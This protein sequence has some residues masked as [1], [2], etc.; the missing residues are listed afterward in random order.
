MKSVAHSAIAGSSAGDRGW[1]EHG[2]GPDSMHEL[3]SQPR[4]WQHVPVLSAANEDV[5]REV[6]PAR[7]R[8]T[9]IVGLGIHCNLDPMLGGYS[10]RH[11][12]ARLVPG[13]INR[14]HGF[15]R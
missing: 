1:I 14:A 11:W 8:P 9:G 4:D 2:F 3:R 7:K 12:A 5:L 6:S 10:L 13:A 15:C